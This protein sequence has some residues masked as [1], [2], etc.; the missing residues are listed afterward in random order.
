[1]LKAA[2]TLFVSIIVRTEL[3][4]RTEVVYFVTVPVQPASGAT[5]CPMLKVAV[6]RDRLVD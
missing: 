4:T 1:V 2:L 6:N 5:D 3:Q